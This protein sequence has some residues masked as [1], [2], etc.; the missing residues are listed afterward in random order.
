M[1]E[2]RASTPPLILPTGLIFLAGL[3]LLGAWSLTIGL[4][5]PLQP[6]SASFEPGL[7]L[8]LQT[9]VIGFMVGWPL[10]RLSQAKVARPAG[11]VWLDLLV[12]MTLLQV[13]IWLP[14]L[15]TS[16]TVA[17][18]IALDLTLLGWMTLVGA[19]IASA[20]GTRR[21]APR[22]LVMGAC[23]LLCLVGPFALAGGRLETFDALDLVLIGP[24]GIVRALTESGATLPSEAQWSAVTLIG[25]AAGGAW[26][27]LGLA[28]VM[29]TKK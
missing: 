9:I 10:L 26:L 28:K 29:L 11:Q 3:W 15:F 18:T 25:L 24:V 20:T 19:M 2:S 6:S 17:R 7:R 8:L 12:L 14:R 23:L 21:T 27:G 4:R 5:M 22:L 16:W 13:V 1:G